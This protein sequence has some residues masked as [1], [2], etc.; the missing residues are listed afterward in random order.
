MALSH[1]RFAYF[2]NRKRIW[3][4]LKQ[5][6]SVI[7]KHRYVFKDFIYLFMFRERERE[8]EG[9]G[10]KHQSVRDTSTG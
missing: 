4:L 3:Q 7:S 8:G 10:E 5:Q 9:K 1:G 2:K 6:K